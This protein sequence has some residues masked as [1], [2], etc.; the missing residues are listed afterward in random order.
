MR[1]LVLHCRHNP[2]LVRSLHDDAPDNVVTYI[3][4]YEDHL[5][6]GS[7]YER[8][9]WEETVDEDAIA[10]IVERCRRLARL[11]GVERWEEIGRDATARLVGLRPIRGAGA[12]CEDIRLEVEPIGAR[13]TVVH[14][15]GHGRSG[16]TLAWGT[17]EEAARLA[18][19]AL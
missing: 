9:V 5:V 3:F 17:A 1:G 4:V 19:E 6:L 12:L 13:G 7:T 18:T 8:D 10:A 15:Y 14:N 16:V 11:D 2:G